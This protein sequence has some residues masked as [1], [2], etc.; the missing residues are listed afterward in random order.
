MASDETLNRYKFRLPQNG[1]P[2]IQELKTT[3]GE[4]DPNLPI[5][6]LLMALRDLN[7]NCKSHEPCNECEQVVAEGITYAK[8]VNIIIPILTKQS[9]ATRVTV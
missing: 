4:F 9:G 3:Y 1:G 2:N 5:C 7:I 8:A 6:V